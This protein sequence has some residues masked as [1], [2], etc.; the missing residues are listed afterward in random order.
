M[1]NNTRV[2]RLVPAALVAA[3]STVALAASPASAATIGITVASQAIPSGASCVF[4]TGTQSGGSS[5]RVGFTPG[6]SA[7]ISNININPGERVH[8]DWRRADCAGGSIREDFRRAPANLSQ[9][10]VWNVN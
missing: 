3:V 9:G 7:R 6:G 5:G 10:G 4:V 2:R 8:F 1:K